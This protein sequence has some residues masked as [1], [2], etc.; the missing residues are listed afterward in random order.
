MDIDQVCSSSI[1]VIM[2]FK[3]IE[4]NIFELMEIGFL[5]EVDKKEYLNFVI[6]NNEEMKILIKVKV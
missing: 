3:K 6:K 4:K 2:D 5:V 1:D